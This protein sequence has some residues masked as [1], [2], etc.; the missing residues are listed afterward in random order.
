MLTSAK[1]ATLG[2]PEIKIFSSKGYDVI[3]SVFD[4]TSKTLLC[5]SNHIVDVFGWQ[6]FG[7]SSISMREVII[8]LIL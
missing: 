6:R 4:V 3:I 1:I 8:A 2:L 5:D 7:N